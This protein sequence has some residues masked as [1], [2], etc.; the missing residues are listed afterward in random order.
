MIEGLGDLSERPRRGLR[1]RAR[2]NRRCQT[3][4]RVDSRGRH[5]ERQ[6]PTEVAIV[7]CRRRR[8]PGEARRRLT[9]RRW[10]A[11]L[12]ASGR[13][14]A[15]G[16]PRRGRMHVDDEPPER[17]LAPRVPSIRDRRGP[18]RA[19]RP[20]ERWRLMA[21]AAPRRWAEDP[22]AARRLPPSRLRFPRPLRAG[23]R[24]R[25]GS[26]PAPARSGSGPV[27]RAG[28]R[29]DAGPPRRAA[30]RSGR[31]ADHRDRPRRGDRRSRT[32]CKVVSR[33]DRASPIVWSDQD[34][35]VTDKKIQGSIDIRVAE[36]R[37]ALRDDPRAA[38]LLGAS[39]WSRSARTATRSTS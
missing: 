34:K 23:A 21:V 29:S 11:K 17:V 15:R 8:R 3:T 19:D 22:P 9:W 37:Q 39:S 1:T 24:P 26:A 4:S 12:P 33:Q 28:A 36:R 6:R 13:V 10:R 30:R 5:A 25:A 35:A 14:R 7:R 18:G 38:H 31:R 2:T 16:T 27:A 32:S 20:R